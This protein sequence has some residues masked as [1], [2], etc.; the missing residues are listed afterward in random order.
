MPSRQACK[1]RAIRADD[2]THVNIYDSLQQAKKDVSE[3]AGKAIHHQTIKRWADANKEMYGY[4]WE[5][6]ITDDDDYM[7]NTIPFESVF[8]FRECVESIFNGGQVRVT[9]ETPRR[10]S[11]FD[12][13]KIVLGE[14]IN[15]S[16]TWSRLC[17]ECAEI[18][19][20][21]GTFS[22][23]G[24]RGTGTPVTD[25]QGVLMIVNA[26]PGRRAQQFR[27]GAMDILTRYLAGD[28]TLH[29]EINDNAARQAAQPDDHPLQVFTDAVYANPKSAKYIICSPLMKGRYINEFYNK[30]VV[31]LLEFS[32]NNRKYIK[33]GCSMD[34][35]D[36]VTTHFKELPGFTIYTI[37]VIDN[38][39]V[40]EKKWKDAFAAYNEEVDVNGSIKT[41]FFIGVSVEEGEQLLNKLCDEQLLRKAQ[42]KQLGDIYLERERREHER[43]KMEHENAKMEH[44]KFK[45]AHELEMKRLEMQL[46]QGNISPS[47]SRAKRSRTTPK[48]D[49]DTADAMEI[50]NTTDT[51]TPT[52]QKIPILDNPSSLRGAYDRWLEVK[53]YFQDVPQPPWKKQFGAMAATYKL[54][55]S[56]MRPFFNY[57][58]A[59]AETK[60]SADAIIDKLDTIRRQHRVAANVFIKSCFYDLYHLVSTT[61]K[62]P[63]PRQDLL[64]ELRAHN[65]PVPSIM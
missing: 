24:T 63:I 5:N 42:E 62:S 50:D 2:P 18:L 54:R 34:F 40:V 8:T 47:T 9:N 56:R 12:I 28:Q 55:F 3:W 23:P 61:T 58:D 32:W 10:V 25:A 7:D 30:P 46:M 4:K 36:R 1:I 45:M 65:L 48:E 60:E 52:E 35:K 27:M 20:R 6:V 11:V 13:L 38:P 43:A 17:A 59:N 44:D 39:V 14:D 19:S 37:S 16:S 29:E 53:D 26:L 31:Y 51:Q 57:M 22:F 49:F 64:Q 33:I 15:P 41:E 21:S